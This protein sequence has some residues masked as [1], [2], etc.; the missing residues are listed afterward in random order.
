[1]PAT[2]TQVTDGLKARLAT[3]SG[4]R[5]YSYQP[6]QLNPPFGFPVLNSVTYH[7]AFNGGDVVFNY[8]IVVVVGRYTDRT[9]DA[10]LDGYLSYSGATSIRAAIEAD[11]TLGGICSTL[12]VQSSADVT[13]LSAGDA[14]FLEIR[15][16]VEVHG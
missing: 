13:S 6:D 2:V 16:L 9:A 8:T 11:K 15:F 1:M 4:L 10:L 12:I 7:R 14:E 3:I 5:A